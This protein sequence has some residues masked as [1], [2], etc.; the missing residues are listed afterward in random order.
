LQTDRK[1]RIVLAVLLSIV[2]VLM[3][4]RLE[5][6]PSPIADEGWALSVART[7]ATTGHYAELVLGEPV[8]PTALN[9]GLP[10]IAPMALSY[11][12]LGVGIWQ[13]RLPSVFWT[14]GC[15]LL[16][17]ALAGRLYGQK[18]A[19]YTVVIAILSTGWLGP[20]FFGKQALGEMPA[21]FF[22]LAGFLLLADGP[23]RSP[24]RGVVAGALWGLAV[25]AKIQL[26]PFLVAS[27]LVL[28]GILLWRRG[29]DLAVSWGL[30]LAALA[31]MLTFTRWLQ[32]QLQGVP[33][34]PLS[35]V[36][37][38]L[39]TSVV[40]RTGPRL[41]ALLSVLALGLPAC[42]GLWHEAIT[43]PRVWHES[44]ALDQHVLLRWG[45]ILFAGSWLVW[46]VTLAAAWT[47][48]LVIPLYV[49][50]IFVAATLVSLS[51]SEGLAGFFK[52]SAQ[53]VKRSTA[54]RT[55]LLA[56]CLLLSLAMTTA[57]TLS[58]LGQG[59][60]RPTDRSVDD[61]AGYL[62]TH[63]EPN[64]V[65]ESYEMELFPLLDRPYHYPQVSSM[66]Q[67][68]RRNARGEDIKVD[69]DPLQVNPAY[70]VT[71]PVNALWGLYNEAIYAG[72]FEQ[73]WSIGSYSVYKRVQRLP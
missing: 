69:Y 1:A 29:R 30:A 8:A 27:A 44:V 67:L 48:Y 13:G 72:E 56:L 36:S 40:P 31:V 39:L 22:T 11:R 17:F 38:L 66:E 7:W 60:G 52:C 50:S 45:A 73:Q 59:Y 51:G 32:I 46:Y 41:A 15:L 19:L 62:N 68:V 28:I 35:E 20:V 9:I 26:L 55:N 2:G 65:I 71:G 47:R 54:N 42:L 43:A 53:A 33:S 70:L 18:V 49:S 4:V 63:T 3:V 64:A 37:L 6:A 58:A 25:A 16:I 24:L 14:L 12:L 10:A 5:D 21:L 57:W 23:A 34:M 61:A